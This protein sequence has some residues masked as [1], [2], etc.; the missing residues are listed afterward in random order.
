MA[1]ELAQHLHGWTSVRNGV[2]ASINTIA[3]QTLEKVG[4]TAAYQFATE[5]LG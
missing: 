1:Q 5:N 3:V 4:V 2:K